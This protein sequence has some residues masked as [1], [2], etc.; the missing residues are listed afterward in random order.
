MEARLGAVNALQSETALGPEWIHGI[1]DHC[2]WHTDA[3]AAHRTASRRSCGLG[4]RLLYRDLL[5]YAD[6]RGR[7]L[8]FPRGLAQRNAIRRGTCPPDSSV[9]SSCVQL[10]GAV[11]LA[12]VAEVESLISTLRR[13]DSFV[14]RADA[15]RRKR[16]TLVLPHSTIGNRDSAFHFEAEELRFLIPGGRSVGHC[17]ANE[18]QRRPPSCSPWEGGSYVATGGSGDSRMANVQHAMGEPPFA[19]LPD[20]GRN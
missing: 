15:P 8:L 11:Y 9:L 7:T 10:P 18:V 5:D 14:R 4:A 17:G 6:S 2:L 16:L 12:R 13:C 19:E 20:T 3:G 1:N